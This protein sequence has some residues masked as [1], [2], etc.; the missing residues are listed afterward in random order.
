MTAQFF[1]NFY[2][3]SFQSL[4]HSGINVAHSVQLLLKVV[5]M[6]GKSQCVKAYRQ[7]P[8][9]LECCSGC[10]LVERRTVFRRLMAGLNTA[11]AVDVER[12]EVY[13]H[14]QSRY[15]LLISNSIDPVSSLLLQ[16]RGNVLEIPSAA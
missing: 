11:R 8:E 3:Y 4:E 13:L 6:E 14:Q 12:I 5:A 9:Q 16:M 15:W 2:F 7:C 1:F 10:M